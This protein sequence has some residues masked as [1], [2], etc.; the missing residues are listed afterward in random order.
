V[1]WLEDGEVLLAGPPAQ[2]LADPSGIFAAWV[3]QQRAAEAVR[4]ARGG[5]RHEA[6]P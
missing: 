2:L 1:V 4:E 5:A 6:V 3:E